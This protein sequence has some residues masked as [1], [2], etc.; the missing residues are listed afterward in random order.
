MFTHYGRDR[1]ISEP[2]LKRVALR[3]EDFNGSNSKLWGCLSE[4][5]QV[6]IP[7][8]SESSAATTS[9]KEMEP[10]ELEVNQFLSAP[11]LDFKK[12]SPFKLWKDN[13]QRY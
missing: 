2:A 10:S 1:K 13:Y 7:N 8:Q 5:L 9:G 11:S 3:D 6:S 12:G 4:I